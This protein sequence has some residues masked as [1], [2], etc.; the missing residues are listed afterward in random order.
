MRNMQIASGRRSAPERLRNRPVRDDFAARAYLYEYWD[1][2]LRGRTRFFRAAALTNSALVEL[3]SLQCSRELAGSAAA[4]LLSAAGCHLE[5]LNIELAG[6][7]ECGELY[8]DDLDSSLIYIEQTALE[9]VLQRE[10]GRAPRSYRQGIQQL[11]R[12]M[13]W[14]DQCVWPLQRWPSCHFYRMALRRARAELGR[15]PDFEAL[16]DRVGIGQALI[17]LLRQSEARFMLKDLRAEY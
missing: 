8:D 2:K 7:V 3:F 11:N 6:R 14:I 16:S 13:L 10:A 5:R 12:L 15:R 17:R 1:A 4:A 9:G